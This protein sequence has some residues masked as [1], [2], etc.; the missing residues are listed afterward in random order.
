M[1]GEQRPGDRIAREVSSWSGV[2]AHSHRFGGTEFRQGRRELGHLHGDEQ[3]DLPF[4]RRI[5]D[6]LIAGHR[7]EPHHVLP[8]SGWVTRRIQGE[9][10]VAGVI[11]LFR[12]NYERRSGSS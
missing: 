1:N 9:A 6:E 5:R 4:P 8:G 7:A 3:A 10:D 2:V 12:L 11:E